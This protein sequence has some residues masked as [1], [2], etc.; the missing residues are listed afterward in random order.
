MLFVVEG[1]PSQRADMVSP[2]LLKG[3]GFFHTLDLPR[4]AGH[5]DVWRA[6]GCHAVW[7][8]LYARR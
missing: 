6:R 3:L 1:D 5:L 2:P 8:P 4:V 7:Q